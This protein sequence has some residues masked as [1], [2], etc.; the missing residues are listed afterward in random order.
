MMKTSGFCSQLSKMVFIMGEKLFEY[1]VNIK[2]PVF[3]S[4]SSEQCQRITLMCNMA[5]QRYILRI[6]SSL[7]DCSVTTVVTSNMRYNWESVHKSRTV[8]MSEWYKINYVHWQLEVHKHFTSLFFFWK[9]TC[10]WHK[11]GDKTDE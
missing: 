1:F 5:L 10:C 3:F 8:V 6:L 4:F 9:L 11:I 2:T 7:S